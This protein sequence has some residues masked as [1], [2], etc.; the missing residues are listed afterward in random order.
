METKDKT[1]DIKK[2]IDDV[3]KTLK[4][5]QEHVQH[6]EKLCDHMIQTIKEYFIKSAE[7]DAKYKR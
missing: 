2:D 5:M 6:C 7:I 1:D 4:E 3:R